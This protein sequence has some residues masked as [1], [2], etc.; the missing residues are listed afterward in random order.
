MHNEL[1]Q[2][3]YNGSCQ[4]IEIFLMKRASSTQCGYICWFD[5]NCNGMRIGEFNRVH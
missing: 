5:V 3:N 4:K 1:R 2:E